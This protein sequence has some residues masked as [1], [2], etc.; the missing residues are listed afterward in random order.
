MTDAQF[1][2]IMRALELIVF[3]VFGLLAAV[4]I[5]GWHFMPPNWWPF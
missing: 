2:S 5:I 1:R 4:V 3:G